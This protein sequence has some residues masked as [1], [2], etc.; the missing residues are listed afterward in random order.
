FAKSIEFTYANPD[1]A[2]IDLHAM[3]PEVD[4]SI[5][6]AQIKS[7]YNLVYNDV[8]TKDGFGNFTDERIQ[9][10]WEYVA[11]ANGLKMDAIDPKKAVNSSF[12]P[13]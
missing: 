1:Q 3:V 2:G 11:E 7:I 10:T 12:K 9:K 8:T 13:E 4:A 6:S 5:V